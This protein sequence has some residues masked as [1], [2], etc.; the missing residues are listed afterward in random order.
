M[1]EDDG[2]RLLAEATLAAEQGKRVAGTAVVRNE[3]MQERWFRAALTVLG[4]GSTVGEAVACADDLLTK[5]VMRGY[6]DSQRVTMRDPLTVTA[7]LSGKPQAC[8]ICGG[9][10]GDLHESWC[11]RLR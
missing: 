9:V 7:V 8:A 2:Q 5:F 10:L 6:G 1:T 3:A 11:S 4:R